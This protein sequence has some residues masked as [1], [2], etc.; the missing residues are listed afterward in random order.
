MEF[1]AAAHAILTHEL[2]PVAVT[3]FSIP[4]LLLRCFLLVLLVANA[5]AQIHVRLLDKHSIASRLQEFSRDNHEREAIIRKRFA[6]SGCKED[7]L[8]EQVVQPELPPNVI[9]VLPGETDGVILVGG[10][11]DKVDE[12]DGVVDNWSGASLL[13]SLLYSINAQKRRHTFVFVGFTAEEKGLLGSAFYVRKLSSDQRSKI[14]GMINF[15]T[16]G[17]GPTEVWASHADAPLLSA[18]ART[19]SAMKLPIETM[20]VENVGTADSES[21][22]D[23]KIPRITIH[24][25]TQKT[26]PVLHSRRDRIDAIKMDDYYATYRLLAGYL[27][28]LDHFLDRRASR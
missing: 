10:H 3:H 17:L 9:C 19:A 24:S 1:M 12:G 20:N 27:A 15:D 18:L 2:C 25:L 11:T 7:Q 22:A 13:P 5:P 8:T 28:N 21:F 26:L 4:K 16:L 14:E 23:F 6:E